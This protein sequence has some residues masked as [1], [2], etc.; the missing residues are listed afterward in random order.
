MTTQ[1][2]CTNSAQVAIT[3]LR[4]LAEDRAVPGRD[5]L[6]NEPQ[7]SGKVAAFANASPVPIAATLAL[8]M[9]VR[10]PAHSSAARNRR[11]DARESHL[12]RD[13]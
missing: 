8:E 12:A 13:Q 3:A 4:Y 7:P 9:I 2:A 11:P 6:R 10:S 1:A 5:L